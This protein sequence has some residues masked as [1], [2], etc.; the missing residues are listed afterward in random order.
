[1][2]YKAT[3]KILQ[4][5]K[6]IAHELLY[7]LYN[8]QLMSLL[9]IIHISKNYTFKNIVLRNITIIIYVRFVTPH[10]GKQ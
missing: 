1:M 9:I 7:L 3:S 5:S 2:I 4:C 8:S 10:L 6:F